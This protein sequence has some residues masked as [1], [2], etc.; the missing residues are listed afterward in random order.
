MLKEANEAVILV[1]DEQDGNPSTKLISAMESLASCD[2]NKTMIP[3]VRLGDSD[4][5]KSVVRHRF[6]MVHAK[7]EKGAAKLLLF[8]I[9]N[10]STASPML[11][12]V[13]KYVEVYL[14]LEMNSGLSGGE[15]MARG[16]NET[17]PH[18]MLLSGATASDIN[19]H[20]QDKRTVIL[21]DSAI[22]S[23]QTMR[24]LIEQIRKSH[25]QIRIA[26]VA[27]IVHPKV[28]ERNHDLN[29]MMRRSGASLVALRVSEDDFTGTE[30]TDTDNRLLTVRPEMDLS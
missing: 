12:E 9:S 24:D 25:R 21:V 28:T 15:P 29:K 17:F 10:P 5:V 27:G 6:D 16:I 8:S 13:H 19:H 22:N 20:L 2:I 7:S 23:G 4:F 18:T 14:A 3:A 30:S 26:V 11:R 1:G